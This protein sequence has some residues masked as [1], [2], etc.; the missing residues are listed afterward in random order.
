MLA[1]FFIRD[2]PG[3]TRVQKNTVRDGGPAGVVEE[4]DG[5]GSTLTDRPMD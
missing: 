4:A 3:I 5:S 2:N 1:P